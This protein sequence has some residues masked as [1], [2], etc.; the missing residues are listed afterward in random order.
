MGDSQASLF[1]QACFQPGMAKATF[2]TGTSVLLNIGG[3]FQL[4]AEGLVCALAWVID[5]QPTYAF[6]GIINYSAATVSWLNTSLD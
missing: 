5:G 3:S 6:E 4:P 1:A 2:G